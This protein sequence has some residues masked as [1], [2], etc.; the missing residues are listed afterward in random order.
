MVFIET[1][2]LG[3][4][5]DSEL[6][7]VV[8][9]SRYKDKFLFSYNKERN[10]WE[11]PGGHIEPGETW[12]QAATREMFEESGAT[13]IK[14]T[15]VCVYKIEKYGMLCFCEII[16]MEDLPE[17]SEMS[18]TMLTEELPE[19]LTYPESTKVFMDKIK[20]YLQKEA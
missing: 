20:E 14:V 13:R 4:C 2:E 10:G 18:K 17:N 7:R 11:I 15:P 16:Q 1:F 6:N 5:P 8:C 3:H 12:K 19:G 9:V